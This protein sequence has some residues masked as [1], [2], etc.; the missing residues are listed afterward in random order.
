MFKKEVV[1]PF[2]FDFI[3]NFSVFFI[4]FTFVYQEK[5][6]FDNLYCICQNLS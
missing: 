4:S 1:K 6:F 3:I 5:I 2:F